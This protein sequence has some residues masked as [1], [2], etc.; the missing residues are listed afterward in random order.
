MAG[1]LYVCSTPIG[2]L[3][4]I[5]LRALRV[6]READLIVG[7]DTRR[8]RKL[9]SHHGIHTRFAPSLFQ[10]AEE[11]RTPEVISLLRAGKT[12]ALVSDAGTP[13]LSDPGYPLVRACVAEGIPVVPIPGP[14]A[15]LAALV[16]SG[17]PMDRFLF[18]GHLPRQ[19]GP[20]RRALE[21]LNDVD[22]TIVFYESP[23]R[24][25]ATLGQ[26]AELY[27]SRSVV[28]ARELTKIHEE[29]VRG[30]AVEVHREFAARG[31]VKGEIVVL[32]SPGPTPPRPA[33]EGAAGTLYQ[34]LLAAGLSPREALQETAARLGLPRRT[35]YRAVHERSE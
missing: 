22:C 34:E 25:C 18:L 16:A 35:V 14:S 3:E 7:E 8:T 33:A 12:V 4:D 24:L 27:G 11:E 26:L 32:L 10:G 6:L 5:T 13:L 31:E 2:N 17:L 28:V 9:L 15:L 20:R 23:H 19:A 1:T 30:T 21:S 29:F